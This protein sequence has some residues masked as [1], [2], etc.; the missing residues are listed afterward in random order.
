MRQLQVTEGH[1]DAEHVVVERTNGECGVN[2]QEFERCVE[3]VAKVAG[4][5]T[6]VY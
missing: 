5:L 1:A 6:L 3:D 4:D 2:V